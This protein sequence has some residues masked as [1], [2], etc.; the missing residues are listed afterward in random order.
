MKLFL[1]SGG[2]GI[3]KRT[4]GAALSEKTNNPL[5]HNHLTTNIVKSIYGDAWLGSASTELLYSLREVIIRSAAES[6]SVQTLIMTHS[7]HAHIGKDYLLW[8]S[9][10]CLKLEVEL[11]VVNL[12]CREEVRRQR[13]LCVERGSLGKPHD[14]GV[15]KKISDEWGNPALVQGNI[16]VVAVVD[17]SDKKMDEVVE[18]LTRYL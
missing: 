2:C 10:L 6:G 15:Y 14:I 7:N 17:V 9:D 4:I 12:T 11:Q 16:P 5:V 8:L 18:I 13:F 3:G 1:I